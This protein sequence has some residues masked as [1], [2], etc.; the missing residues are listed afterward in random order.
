MVE[1]IHQSVTSSRVP[2]PGFYSQARSMDLGGVLHV[3]TS[4]QCGVVDSAGRVT[5]DAA[6]QTYDSLRH[7]EALL[8][9][10]GGGAQDIARTT[11][12]VVGLH[13]NQDLVCD[14]YAR[15]FTERS[16]DASRAP[17]RALIGVAELP[18]KGEGTLVEIVADAYISQK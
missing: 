8:Q 4:G 9:E 11:V 16:I 12:Y 2:K 17:A 7:I 6:R 18:F 5:G 1:P 13:T 10:V 3:L 15:F 14:A